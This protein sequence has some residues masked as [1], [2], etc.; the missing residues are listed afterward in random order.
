VTV[1]ADVCSANHYVDAEG[2]HVYGWAYCTCGADI[3]GVPIYET[4]EAQR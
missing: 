2:N 1:H 4:E 3:A